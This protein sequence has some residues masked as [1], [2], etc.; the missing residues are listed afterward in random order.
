MSSPTIFISKQ[1]YERISQLIFGLQTEQADLL[2]EELDR[3]QIVDETE[4][5]QGTIQIGSTVRYWDSSLN[6]E[7]TCQLTLPVEA[8]L[9]ENKISILAPVGAALI[10][11]QINQEIEWP[12]PNGQTKKIK[13][14]DV[15]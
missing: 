3:A 14:L 4:V 10:G 2:A 5:P 6:K 12:L 15:Q 9:N 7:S 11:L 1:D 8:N 13:I